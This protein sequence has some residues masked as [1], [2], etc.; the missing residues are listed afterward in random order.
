MKL[1]GPSFKVVRVDNYDR[2]TVANV[3]VDEGLDELDVEIIC[4]RL[5]KDLMRD[6]AVWYIV[7]L[8]DQKLCCVVTRVY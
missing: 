1:C 5:R 6:D 8:Q 2:E 7:Y 3:A 4:E